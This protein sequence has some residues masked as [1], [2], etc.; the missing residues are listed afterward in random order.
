MNQEKIINFQNSTFVTQFKNQVERVVKTA[1]KKIVDYFESRQFK[2]HAK[3]DGSFVT[4]A[5][6]ESEAL[7]IKG[8]KP[9]IPLA[10]FCT[11]ESE[12]LKCNNEYVWVID[13]LDGTANF[14]AG[15]AHFGISIALVHYKKVI[16]SF[17]YNPVLDHFFYTFA[18]QSGAYCNNKIICC[19]GTDTLKSSLV[20]S[21]YYNVNA[22]NSRNIFTAARS[23]RITGS[24][25]LDQAYC[26]A[27]VIDV[28]LYKSL[29]WWDIAAGSLLIMQAEGSVRYNK[30]DNSLLVKSFTASNKLVFNQI[31][32]IF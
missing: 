28:V 24:A 11:E 10:G 3:K 22:V 1:G 26:A 21:H 12:V 16:A 29:K 18:D 7:L 32:K 9:L 2:C 17:I 5:D 30:P 31:S 4:Q 6:T 8:L 19:S 20:A 23:V 25:V 14:V 27:G 13:P 15:I